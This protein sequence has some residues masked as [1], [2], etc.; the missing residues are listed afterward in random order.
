LRRAAQAKRLSPAVAHTPVDRPGNQRVAAKRSAKQLLQTLAAGEQGLQVHARMHA[1]LMQHRD[2]ILGGDVAS[3][4]GGHRAAAKLTEARLEALHP[5][6][7]RGEHVR[8]ALSARVVEVSG[9]LH[10]AS[11]PLLGEAEELPHLHRVRH[12]RR[13]SEADL[14]RA[15][16]AQAQRDLDHALRRDVAL[17]GTPERGRDHALAAQA[18][19]VSAPQHCLRP[20]QRLRDRAVDVPAVVGLR[21]R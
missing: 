7:Q 14:L 21:G 2:E 6:L 11:E 12:P 9:E 3:R 16:V 20:A 19:P 15:S 5:S 4:A 10:L 17:V 8:Q 13:V 1:H 18:L